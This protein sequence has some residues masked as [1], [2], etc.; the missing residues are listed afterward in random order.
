MMT[1]RRIVGGSEETDHYLIGGCRLASELQK[2]TYSQLI[3]HLL[4]GT[5]SFLDSTSILQTK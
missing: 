4:V 3:I 1:Y 5:A 2:Q